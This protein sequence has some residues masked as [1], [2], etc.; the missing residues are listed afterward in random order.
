MTSLP[1]D[2]WFTI[3]ALDKDTYAISEY[4]HWE[5]V[6]S[7]LILGTE[8]AA[9]IDTG[10]G[11]DHMKRVTDQLT[12]L[13]IIVLTTHVHWDHIGSH[14]E[15]DNIWVHEAEEQWLVQGIPGLSIEQIRHD[16]SRDITKPLPL[17]F[18]A[19]SYEPFRGEPSGLLRDQDPIE[20]GNRQLT[21]FHTPGHSP[22]HLSFLDQS[23]GYLFTGDLL[24]SDTPIYAFYPT[25][26][27]AALVSSLERIS[28]LR[29]VTKIYGGHNKLGLEPELLVEVRQAVQELRERNCIRH[30]TGIH[31]FRGFSVH[32]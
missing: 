18:S 9:L 30:G 23:R 5:K 20:L 17:D 27:P 32:F 8:R 1:K 11:I 4:G 7:Y 25:T 19:A 24:Y 26:E 13:P 10:T 14:G 6:H 21:V 29:G 16:V 31:N 12:S 28:D 3:T 2:P 22:G 15:Y